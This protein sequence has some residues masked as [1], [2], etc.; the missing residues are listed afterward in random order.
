MGSGKNDS[1]QSTSDLDVENDKK[2]E[3]NFDDARDEPDSTIPKTIT[4]N[5]QMAQAF[6][7]YLKTESQGNF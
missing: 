4:S 5:W 7:A 6:D 3:P 1:R 2:V